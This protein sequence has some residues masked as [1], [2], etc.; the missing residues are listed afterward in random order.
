MEA[1]G[2]GGRG[3]DKGD[4]MDGGVWMEGRWMEGGVWMEGSGWMEGGMDGVNM[5]RFARFDVAYRFGP[6]WRGWMEGLA[7]WRGVEAEGGALIKG[8]GWM[9]VPGWRAAGWRKVDWR[10][11][12][13]GK[14]LDGGMDGV[15]MR[16]GLRASMSCVVSRGS[17][18]LRFTGVDGSWRFGSG[19]RFGSR[20]SCN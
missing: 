13:G 16:L 4:W 1:G 2:G 3:L 15:K 12:D 14:W 19:L 20:P 9:E 8:A 11:L 18:F 10:G 6:G 17:R 5:V 7:Q